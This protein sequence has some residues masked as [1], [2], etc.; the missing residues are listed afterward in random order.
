MGGIG[1]RGVGI[2]NGTGGRD[3]DDTADG[4]CPPSTPGTT[5]GGCRPGIIIIGTAP[6]APNGVDIGIGN[7][8]AT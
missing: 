1:G 7:V 5:T 4:N 8:D 2:A 6:K 3:A